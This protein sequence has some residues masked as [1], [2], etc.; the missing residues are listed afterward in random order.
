MSGEVQQLRDALVALDASYQGRALPELYDVIEAARKVVDVPPAV[1]LP[2]DEPQSVETRLAQAHERWQA[3]NADCT[4]ASILLLAREAR[5]RWPE[6]K[7]I[8]LDDS[9]QGNYYVIDAVLDAEGEDLDEDGD[10]DDDNGYAGFL[11]DGTFAT[12]APFCMKE[13]TLPRTYIDKRSG[14]TDAILDIDAI[15]E[16]VKPS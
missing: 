9:D 3:A 11:D 13:N 7:G 1:E 5:E 2:D 15:L 10:F 8:R 6:A 12:F 16:G 14:I 4:L